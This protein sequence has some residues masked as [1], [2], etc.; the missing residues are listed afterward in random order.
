LQLEVP[1]GESR[2]FSL[3]RRASA[4]KEGEEEGKNEEGGM[5]VFHGK[6]EEVLRAPAAVTAAANIAASA[7]QLS[8][9]HKPN[10]CLF[11]A[12]ETARYALPVGS[13]A[14]D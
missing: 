1:L 7:P 8:P 4:Q 12:S 3:I 5:Q 6:K 2:T 13:G 14:R 9:P 10:L 11:R